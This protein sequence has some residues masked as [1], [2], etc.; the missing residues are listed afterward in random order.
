[1]YDDLSGAEMQTFDYNQPP[2][3]SEFQQSS[4][5]LP[6][7]PQKALAITGVSYGGAGAVNL[8][9]SLAS[10]GK[11]VNYMGLFDPSYNPSD[12]TGYE[13]PAYPGHPTAPALPATSY[14]AP[15]TGGNPID[16]FVLPYNVVS[17]DT[18][19]GSDEWSHEAGFPAPAF[20]AI[21][22]TR[23]FHNYS[24]TYDANVHP[25]AW[26]YLNLDLKVAKQVTTQI[27]S[28]RVF[29]IKG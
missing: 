20:P 15:G 24:N 29:N 3:V 6:T 14:V 17:A 5:P 18:W 11:T 1:M 10:V 4:I 13:N 8:A 9:W 19:Y 27:K 25:H 26:P 21:A 16:H 23:D 12:P 7:Q 2:P 22:N 28:K